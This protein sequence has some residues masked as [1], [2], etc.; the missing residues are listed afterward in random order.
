MTSRLRASSRPWLSGSLAGGAPRLRGPRPPCG[1]V[2][3]RWPPCGD[4]RVVVVSAVRAGTVPA[5]DEGVFSLRHPRLQAADRADVERA[6]PR[7]H[8]SQRFHIALTI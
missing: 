6:S 4:R 1:S 7:N 3:A 8:D 2:A 5:P